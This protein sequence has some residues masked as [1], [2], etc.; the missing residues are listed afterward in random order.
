M[1]FVTIDGA[2][3][4]PDQGEQSK[5]R[6]ILHFVSALKSCSTILDHESVG[7]KYNS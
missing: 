4:M 5:S 1:Y 2:D 3:D 6:K 7:G